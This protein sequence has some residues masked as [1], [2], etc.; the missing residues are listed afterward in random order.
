MLAKYSI[1]RNTAPSVCDSW[2]FCK[3]ITGA[4]CRQKLGRVQKLLRFDAVRSV[5]LW[6]SSAELWFRFQVIYSVIL[7]IL[8]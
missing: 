4:R 1:T 8:Q 3:I 7:T 2:A 5:G 6:R